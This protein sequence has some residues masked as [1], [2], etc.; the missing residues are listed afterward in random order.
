[1]RDTCP[2]C[3]SELTIIEGRILADG[4]HEEDTRLCPHGHPVD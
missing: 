2:T 1:M 4:T 3:G